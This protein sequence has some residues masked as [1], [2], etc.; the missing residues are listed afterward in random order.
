MHVMLSL[1]LNCR[2]EELGVFF[3]FFLPQWQLVITAL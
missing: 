3:F 2:V 1:Q